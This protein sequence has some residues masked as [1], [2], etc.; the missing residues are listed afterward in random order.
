MSENIEKLGS[1]MSRRM[2]ATNEAMATRFLELGRIGDNMSL[3]PD[4]FMAPIAKGEYMVDLRLTGSLDTTYTEHKHSGG[5]H[6]QQEG[7]G[8][9][10]HDGGKHKHEIP[11]TLRGLH[12]GDRVLIAWCGNEAVVI[13]IVVSS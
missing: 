13:A 4:N 11:N 9:H 5:Q 6:A 1:L 2:Q 12:P 3:L 8:A 10:S 7:T